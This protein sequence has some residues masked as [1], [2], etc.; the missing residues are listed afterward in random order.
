MILTKQQLRY[1]ILEVAGENDVRSEKRKINHIV[2]SLH[3]AIKAYTSEV[4]SRLGKGWT[5]YK[6]DNEEVAVETAMSKSVN[7]ALI[8]LS[9]MVENI[10]GEGKSRRKKL[11]GLLDEIENHLDREAKERKASGDDF[12]AARAVPGL[13][14][15]WDERE[16]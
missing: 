13:K 15:P 16:D 3:D 5:H 11:N 8:E 4:H 6:E 9:Y 2:K 1:L 12:K 10:G 7:D 14:E